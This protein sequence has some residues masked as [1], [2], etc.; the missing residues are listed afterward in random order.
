MESKTDDPMK[1]GNSMPDAAVHCLETQ[2][3]FLEERKGARVED[4]PSRD[5]R[6]LADIIARVRAGDQVAF[7]NLI[8]FTQ[9]KSFGL[10]FNLLGDYHQAQDLLQEAYLRVFRH[11]GSLKKTG[12]FRGWMAQIITNLAR[13]YYHRKKEKPLELH[14][15]EDP[16]AALQ[17]SD[18]MLEG[19][20]KR[21]EVRRA[22]A[23]LPVKERTM[24][25]LREYYELSYEEMAQVL[26]IPLGTVKSRLNE[27]RKKL[28]DS[29]T[30]KEGTLS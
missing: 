5:E 29:V 15:L 28:V 14:D 11:I 26:K 20:M 7:E 2:D 10:A 1:G 16:A 19:S 17:F 23:A 9:K 8:T 24:L 3:L 22:L 21:Q 13:D 18:E 30:K 27:A 12:A 4:S 6:V 25:V